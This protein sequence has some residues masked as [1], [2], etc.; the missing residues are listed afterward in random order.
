MPRLTTLQAIQQAQHEEMRRDPRVFVMGEDIEANMFGTT[1]GFA[2]EFG[3]ERV[4][5][6]PISEAGFIG[7]A[8]GAAMVGMRPI[9]DITI[10]PFLYPAMDQIVSIVAKSTYL[11]GGQTK[12]PVVIRAGMMYACANAAQHSDRPYPMFMGVPGL[13]IAIPSTPA[14][15]KGLLKTAIRDDDPVLIFEDS[16]LWGATGDVPEGE[17]LLPFGQAAIR[18]E[19]TDVTVVALTGAVQDALAA[20]EV[21]AGEGVSVE[22]IDPRTLV[23]LDEAAILASV[24]KTGRLVAVDVAHVTCSVASEIAAIVA[25]RGFWDLKSPVL[26]VAVPQTHIPFS[27]PLEA[28]LYPT[29]DR[30]AAAVRRTLE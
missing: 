10:A 29:K 9:V 13:K 5:N 11:Y 1:S 12:V 24:K 18:R 14:D 23:P 28:Q 27:P 19:G 20:A 16:R 25:E 7:V 6:T 8:A 3:R 22:V 2:E 26:R 4:R 17:H 30:I 21:L 15:A